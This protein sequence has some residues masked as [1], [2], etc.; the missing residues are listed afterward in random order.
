MWICDAPSS[1]ERRASAAYSAGVYGIAG[2]WSRFAIAP[3][4]EQLM[5]TGSSKRLISL[6][7]VIRKTA[8]RGPGSAGLWAVRGR[9]RSYSAYT[10]ISRSSASG[11][12]PSVP[13]FEPPPPSYRHHPVLLPWALDA[14]ARGHSQA[15][16]DRGARL[17][18]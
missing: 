4:I 5:T 16:D 6:P 10:R 3:L 11:R 12:P 7:P 14:L 13:V 18:R 8:H 15:A 2:H 1:T 9:K 17:A